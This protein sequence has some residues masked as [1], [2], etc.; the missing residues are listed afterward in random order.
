MQ[1]SGMGGGP[2]SSVAADPRRTRATRS[3]I[4]MMRYLSRTSHSAAPAQADMLH[5]AAAMR[6]VSASS[7]TVNGRHVQIEMESAL[8]QRV[9]LLGK[10]LLDDAAQK[11]HARYTESRAAAR[12]AAVEEQACFT[13][14]CTE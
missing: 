10:V 4:T 5:Q 8:L 6:P 7:Q 11:A 1:C 2:S 13:G 12:L 14:A 9:Q 3:S